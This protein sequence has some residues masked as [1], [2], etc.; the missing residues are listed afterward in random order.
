MMK[1]V[2][3]QP[4]FTK[5]RLPAFNELCESMGVEGVVLASTKEGFGRFEERYSQLLLKDCN[6]IELFNKRAYYQVGLVREVMNLRDVSFLFVS[7]D[8]RSFSTWLLFRFHSPGERTQPLLCMAPHRMCKTCH[9][10]LESS[11]K[12]RVLEIYVPQAS[13]RTW[14]QPENQ[15][16]EQKTFHQFQS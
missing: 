9:N 12:Q 16:R 1:A 11:K 5:Y 8:P 6:R 2:F 10:P 3:V 14:I 4:Y 13:D 15:C 7:A